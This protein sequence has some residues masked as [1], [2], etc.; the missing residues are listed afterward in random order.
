MFPAWRLWKNDRLLPRQT[1]QYE[2]DKDPLEKGREDVVGGHSV[3]FTREAVVERNF[4]RK[5]PT[6]CKSSVGLDGS[7][8]YPYSMCQR[9]PTCIYTRWDLK[10][11]ANR[12]TL[13]QNKTRC[14]AKMVMSFL[15]RLIPDCKKESF[16]TTF[17]R[18][19]NDCFS[20][21]GCCSPCSAKFEAIGCFYQFCHSQKVRSSLT[22]DD[23]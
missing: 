6:M 22:E 18:K 14:F 17:E 3:V 7:Q 1:Y 23:I 21:E 2:A 13:R 10:P 9:M 11:Q 12:F 16:Y 19:K 20:V 15:Q 4:T 5:S 8:L